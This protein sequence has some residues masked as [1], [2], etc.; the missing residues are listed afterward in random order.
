M[1]SSSNF[2]IALPD[3]S[4]VA[5]DAKTFRH[6]RHKRVPELIALGRVSD[7]IAVLDVLASSPLASERDRLERAKLLGEEQDPRAIAAYE[8]LVRKA[9]DPVA[10]GFGLARLLKERENERAAH[11][12]LRWRAWPRDDRITTLTAQAL[13]R[14]GEPIVALDL[15]EARGRA[16]ITA[17]VEIQLR[18]LNRTGRFDEAFL[19]AKRAVKQGADS[20][21][22]QVEKARAL[23]RLNRKKEMIAAL[24]D[25][26]SKDRKNVWALQRRGELLLQSGDIG[27]SQLDLTSALEKAPHLNKARVALARSYKASGEYEVSAEL[28]LEAH[29]LEPDNEGIRKLAAAGLNQAGRQSE[30]S[31]LYGELIRQRERALPENFVKGIQTLGLSCADYPIPQAR[32]DWAWE[33]RDKDQWSDRREWERR[34]RWGALADKLLYDW[35]ECRP[36]RIEEILPLLED[37]DGADAAVAPLLKRGRGLLVASAHI[38][39]MFAGPL[40]LELLGFDNKWLASV[41]SV[42]AVGFANKLISTADQTE[43]QVVRKSMRALASGQVLTVAVDGTMS[44]SAPRVDFTNQSIT[45]SSFGARLSYKQKAP[46]IFAV[47]RWEDDRIRIRIR[48][49]PD[50]VHATDLSKFLDDWRSAYLGHIAEMLQDSPENLR[51]SGGLWRDIR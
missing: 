36:D 44:M 16:A 47:P 26:L 14:G 19:L 27:G 40:I 38:G 6:W 32:L 5:T 50:P 28:I 39:L 2:Q 30:A 17:Q 33:M 21:V 1:N 41:P 8:E 51:L 34:A 29:R 20:L 11:L 31:D 13:S 48:S 12:A 24:G 22:I 4:K 49:L 18:L 46:S 3:A 35:L 9:A 23:E 7:A 10:I 43:G 25:V 45:Y 15:L 37:L 42:S